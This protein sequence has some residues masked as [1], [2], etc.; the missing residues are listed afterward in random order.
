M[1]SEKETQ[2]KHCVVRGNTISHGI[3]SRQWKFLVWDTV[4]N[5]AI[6]PVK[7]SA[8]LWMPITK[9][10]YQFYN[11]EQQCKNEDLLL[12][13]SAAL[14]YGLAKITQLNRIL[15]TIKQWRSRISN[16]HCPFCILSGTRN[17]LRCAMVSWGGS[18]EVYFLSQHEEV[19]SYESEGED[20]H[21]NFRSWCWSDWTSLPT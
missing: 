1:D 17:K 8:L 2:V 20:I 9:E 12:P 11:T 19:P 21:S 15:A 10:K 3:I 18:P 7:N 13:L 5:W 6:H 16:W 14:L 4:G